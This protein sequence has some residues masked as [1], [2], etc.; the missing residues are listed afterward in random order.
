[1]RMRR[2]AAFA[3]A[4]AAVAVGAAAAPAAAAEQGDPIARA[5][6]ALRSG[7]IYM[8]PA[9]RVK[10]SS[11]QVRAL[12]RQIATSAP[13][14]IF[15]AVLPDSARAAAGGTVAGVGAALE[16]QVGRPGIYAIIVGSRFEA[17]SNVMPGGEAASLASVSFAGHRSQ[18]PF[19]V[20]TN[21]VS[22]AAN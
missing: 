16:R 22:L 4:L 6:A 12:P 19:A 18:G 17:G 3:L 7:R 5:A 21:F 13:R 9:A 8:D 11:A 15:V 20:L 2:A 14:R 1:R 10:L